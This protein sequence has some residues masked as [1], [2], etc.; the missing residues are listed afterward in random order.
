MR[1]VLLALVLTGCVAVTIN[2]QF[3]QE[4]IEGAAENIEDLVRT[5]KE[6]PPPG[7]QGARPGASWLAWITPRAAEAQTV[8]ELKTR[9][10]EIMAMIES[11][12]NRYPSLAAAMAKGCVGE[13]NRGFVEARS[14]QGCAPDVAALVAAENADR[15]TLYRTLIEQNKMPPE[16]LTRVQAAFGKINREKAPP[17]SSV[18]LDSGEWTRR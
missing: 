14:G 18:Q 10:P 9:T 15:M 11:R 4:K 12:R 1:A 13:N 16:D 8:P 3:P 6:L 5:P 7:K 17:G 2:V